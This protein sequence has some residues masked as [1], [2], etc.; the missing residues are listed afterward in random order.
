M[1]NTFTSLCI[2]L[3]AACSQAVDSAKKFAN[4]APNS[5]ACTAPQY[6]PNTLIIFFDAQIGNQALLVAIK[7]YSAEILYE[8]RSMNG[9]AIRLPNGTNL[10]D[11]IRHFEQVKGVLMVNKDQIMQL[12]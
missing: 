10:D 2:L 11:A 1:K 6:S 9:V 8:Y 5:T 4:C 12:E 7:A 3:L